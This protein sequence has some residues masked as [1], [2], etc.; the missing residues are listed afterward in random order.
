MDP[1][2]EAKLILLLRTHDGA[3]KMEQEA[4]DALYAFIQG[5]LKSAKRGTV[6]KLVME[7][8]ERTKLS[9]ARIYAIGAGKWSRTPERNPGPGLDL[10]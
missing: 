9:R 4:R 10:V 3:S 8:A 6:E 1:E 7:L 2:D 5:K